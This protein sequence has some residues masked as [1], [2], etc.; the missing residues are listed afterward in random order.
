MERNYFPDGLTEAAV[1]RLIEQVDR[2]LVA[3]EHIESVR[4]ARN[5]T[6]AVFARRSRRRSG[7]VALRRLPA[8]SLSA[9]LADLENEAA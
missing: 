6:N 8:R 1:D 4:V 2:E 3:E 7:K 5:L 9:T